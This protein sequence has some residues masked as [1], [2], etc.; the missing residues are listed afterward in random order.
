VG[1][2]QRVGSVFTEGLAHRVWAKALA[3]A[4][5]PRGDEA[6]AHLAICLRAIESGEA[7][8]PAAHVQLFWARLCRDRMDTAAALDHAQRA[9]HQFAASQLDDEL[10]MARSLIDDLSAV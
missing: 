1:V 2:A 4:T 9:A 7:H 6:E 5:P 8:L 10:S 3:A